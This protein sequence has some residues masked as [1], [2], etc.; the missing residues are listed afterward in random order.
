MYFFSRVRKPRFTAVTVFPT[1]P[2]RLVIA[3]T[4]TVPLPAKTIARRSLDSRAMKRGRSASRNDSARRPARFRTGRA[5]DCAGCRPTTAPGTTSTPPPL[6][7]PTGP[8][9]T[10]PMSTKKEQLWESQQHQ[11]TK[12]SPF[13]LRRNQKELLN[14]AFFTQPVALK[15]QNSVGGLE[16]VIF[17]KR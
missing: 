11:T 9:S 8:P 14:W 6:P 13:G 5:G 4:L 7:W 12:P 1:P 10:G 15:L 16:R 2:L 17:G 3:R